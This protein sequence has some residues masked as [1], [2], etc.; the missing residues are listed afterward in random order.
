MIFKE[1]ANMESVGVICHYLPIIE[2]N[3]NRYEAELK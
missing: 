1:I 3:N 2:N